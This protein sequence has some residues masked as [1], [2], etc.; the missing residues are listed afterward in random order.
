MVF[1]PTVDGSLNIENIKPLPSTSLCDVT[2]VTML[3]KVMVFKQIM[4]ASLNIENIKPPRGT[5]DIMTL[6]RVGV[7]HSCRN[8]NVLKREQN[9]RPKQRE[10]F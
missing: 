10:L 6:V 7:T 3:W 8:E 1:K 4:H 5:L 9:A 2:D